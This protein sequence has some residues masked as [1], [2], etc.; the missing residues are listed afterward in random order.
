M[1]YV[2]FEMPRYWRQLTCVF[3]A[4]RRNSAKKQTSLLPRRATEHRSSCDAITALQ[5]GHQHLKAFAVVRLETLGKWR[6]VNSYIRGGCYCTQIP[7]SR[8]WGAARN[9]GWN[10]DNSSLWRG[11]ISVGVS[12]DSTS[13]L[14]HRP[15]SA[16]LPGL[17]WM[18]LIVRSFPTLRLYKG[19]P[20]AT[21]VLLLESPVLT[22]LVLFCFGLWPGYQFFNVFHP[23]QKPQVSVKYEGPRTGDKMAEWAKVRIFDALV[24]CDCHYLLMTPRFGWF[25][26]FSNHS[27]ARKAGTAWTVQWGSQQMISKNHSQEVHRGSYH[28]DAGPCSQILWQGK[29][30]EQFVERLETQTKLRALTQEWALSSNISLIL[31]ISLSQVFSWDSK[32]LVP[33]LDVWS[34]TPA[35][36]SSESIRAQA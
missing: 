19:G 34:V 10:F 25:L 36:P 17:V 26:H 1:V 28:I 15:S 30:T 22:L 9:S 35:L 24:T 32:H 18:F 23:F 29:L 2:I 16:S 12:G 4:G 14:H 21:N 27:P 13:Y 3:A 11:R 20:K 6:N 5:R 33:K 7:R 8:A 31:C